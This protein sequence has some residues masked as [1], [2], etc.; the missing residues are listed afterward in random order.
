[1]TGDEAILA[2]IE[3]L[4]SS[5][6]PY[7]VVGSLSSNY[8]GIP[9][10][11]RD[12][13][14]VVALE[15]VSVHDIRKSLSQEF[16]LEPQLAFETITG[17][18][19]YELQVAG[20]QFVVELF[21]LSDDA[22]DQCRFARRRCVPFLG[23]EAYVPTAEDVIVT[24]LRWSMHAHRAKDRDDARNVMAVQLVHLDWAYLTFWCG[25]HGTLDVLNE[26]RASLPGPGSAENCPGT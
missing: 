14:F 16:V 10:S 2:V 23:R 12:A 21:V 19:R 6:V 25:E 20:T 7:M 3:A 15:G 8:Y 1:M 17:T 5:N 22:Y 4:E 26:L 13:D 9:R 24:K 18:Q 11:T